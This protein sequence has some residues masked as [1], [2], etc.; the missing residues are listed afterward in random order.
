MLP[1][2][3]MPALAGY[4][5]ALACAS[6]PLGWGLWTVAFHTFVAVAA[7]A[8][9]IVDRRTR[10]R[11]LKGADSALEFAAPTIRA[12]CDPTATRVVVTLTRLG[13]DEWEAEQDVETLPHP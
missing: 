4:S 1:S 11:A 5:A 3:L 6:F 2:P 10:T 13:L 7:A 8:L 9:T 12:M